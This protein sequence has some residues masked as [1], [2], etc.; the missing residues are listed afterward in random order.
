MAH[1]LLE[2]IR[3]MFSLSFR[4]GLSSLSVTINMAIHRT[5]FRKQFNNIPKEEISL[6]RWGIVSDWMWHKRKKK[7]KSQHVAAPLSSFLTNRLLWNHSCLVRKKNMPKSFA[8]RI[9]LTCHSLDRTRMEEWCENGHFCRF[10]L[11]R[12]HSHNVEHLW[13]IHWK[14]F[15]LSSIAGTTAE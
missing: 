9:E 8:N 10:I 2:R 4:F 3:K 13:K 1:N 11:D 6:C 14:M 15:I 5:H 12:T 7:L